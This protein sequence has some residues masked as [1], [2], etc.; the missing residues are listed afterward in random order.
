MSNRRI[1]WENT[2]TRSQVVQIPI[3]SRML[4][5]GSMRA[6]TTCPVTVFLPGQATIDN[7]AEF[8]V[9]YILAPWTSAG[10]VQFEWKAFKESLPE[11]LD[12][13]IANRQIPACVVVAPDLYTPFGGSQYVNSAFLG[14]H[15][16]HLVQELIPFV[17]GHF[18]VKKGPRFRGIFGRS[19]GG[20]GALRLAQDYPGMFHAVA[21]HSGDLGF[22]WVYRRELIVLAQGL[23][24]YQGN[25]GTYLEYCR[26]ATKLSGHDTH[27]LMLLGMA[28]TYSPNP[29]NPD[30][31]EI[32]VD[33]N[34]GVLRENIWEQWLAHDPIERLRQGADAGLKKLGCLYVD[35][36]FKDQYFLH[37]GA[38]QFSQLMKNKGISHIHEEFDDNHSG[39]DYRYDRSLPLLLAALGE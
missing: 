35:C 5:A 23:Q 31:F 30:G 32:P 26:Q 29:Q 4:P 10:R 39:T 16:D 14:P 9:L 28:A 8:P 22:E 18:P 3:Q 11:R 33:L 17:E 6:Q 38:R 37:Y 20:F 36:G 27:L 34:T 13:L 15:G 7:R 21:S 2:L 19:S 1:L 24:R 12:R 25:V